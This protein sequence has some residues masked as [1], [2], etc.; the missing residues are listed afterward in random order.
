MRSL[1]E[2][3]NLLLN[4]II[5]NILMLNINDQPESWSILIN[6]GFQSIIISLH[7]FMKWILDDLW[8]EFILHFVFF[9]MY[10][11]PQK[12]ITSLIIQIVSFIISTREANLD[13]LAN[14]SSNEFGISVNF[15][16][17]SSIYKQKNQ[18]FQQE[19][20]LFKKIIWSRL[21]NQ[22]LITTSINIICFCNEHMFS[23]SAN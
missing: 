8:T 20:T 15:L 19:I 10:S 7:Q 4:R 18:Q 11:F 3:L 23:W 2:L 1:C 22:Q 16:N 6:F 9:Y 5:Q 21:K 12:W 14:I 13:I 17:I